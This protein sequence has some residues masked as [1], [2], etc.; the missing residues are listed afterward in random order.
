MRWI[1]F[2]LFLLSALAA[3]LARDL[4]ICDRID[5]ALERKVPV[6]YN[7]YLQGGYLNMP[8]ARMAE[9]S[10]DAAASAGTAGAGVSCPRAGTE[11]LARRSAGPSAF[12]EEMVIFAA[13]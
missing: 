4:E 13:Q 10:T 8:S 9:E 5:R 12:F 7:F 3:D 1:V 2:F 11:V 6:F